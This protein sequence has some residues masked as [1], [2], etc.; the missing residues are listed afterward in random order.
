MQSIRTPRI[1]NRP[2]LFVILTIIGIFILYSFS[3]Q[4]FYF[5]ERV[6]EQ[7][8]G[9]KFRSGRIVD[10]VGPGVYSDVGLFVEIRRVS[11]EAV[12]FR[13]TDEELITKDKQRIG[14]VVTGDVFRPGI[15]HVDTIRK[16]WAQYNAHY[17]DDDIARLTIEDRARQA[18]K[19]CVG[20]KIFDEA[21]I[22][23]ARDELRSCIDTELDELANSYG[24]SVDNVAV[25]DV[26]LL[27]DAQARLDEIVQSRLQTEKAKQDELRAKAEAAAEQARQE[28]EIRVQQS[29]IQEEARQQKSLAELDREK[30]EA[31]K[32]VIEAERANELARVE[33]ERAIIEAEK[34]NELLAATRELE[35]QTARAAAAAEQAKADLA[36][37]IAL[38]EL[39]ATNPG[40]LQL[41]MAETNAAALQATDKIIFTPEGVAP[42]LVIPGPGIVPT[43]DTAPHVSV[44][45]DADEASAEESSLTSQASTE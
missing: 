17:L 22:G 40:Y 20:D 13:V 33:A 37:Q 1:G 42:T 11:S 28:G 12:P 8:V 16:L 41:Q 38:A 25:P 3:S 5:F 2:L 30:I 31:Q 32:A 29:R 39:L 23:T 36:P 45:T 14:L 15:A 26:I 7:E 6:E 18:M 9:V 24:L 10:V 4:F 27:P 19:V 44:S 35:I 34:N 21:V 43:V